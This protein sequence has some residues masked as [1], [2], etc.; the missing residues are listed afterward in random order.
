MLSICNN[1]NS[2]SKSEMKATI[3]INNNIVKTK[4]KIKYVKE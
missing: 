3:I 2:C 4:Q 1:F